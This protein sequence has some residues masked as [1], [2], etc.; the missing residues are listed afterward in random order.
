MGKKWQ[1]RIRSR[2][3]G[4]KIA[5]SE[6]S[7]RNQVFQKLLHRMKPANWSLYLE[8]KRSLVALMGTVVMEDERPDISEF[9][10]EQEEK[11]LG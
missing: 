6:Q 10:G 3:R 7:P 1:G 11:N 2:E 8:M 9:K 4:K 5:E